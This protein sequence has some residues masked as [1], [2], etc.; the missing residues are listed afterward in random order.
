M[1]SETSWLWPG[2]RWFGG[3]YFAR[4]GVCEPSPGSPVAESG[5]AV[6]ALLMA[7]MTPAV[8]SGVNGLIAA[9]GD[10]DGTNTISY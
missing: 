4:A 1:Y 5:R 8:I 10:R 9:T 3:A 6:L 2:Y 7:V